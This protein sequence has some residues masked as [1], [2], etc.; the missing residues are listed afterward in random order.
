MTFQRLARIG[1]GLAIALAGF[2]PL[3]KNVA[4]AADLGRYI[5]PDFCAAL[6]VHPA[7]ITK[8]KLWEAIKSGLPPAMA[9]TDP[10]KAAIESIAHDKNA[11]PGIDP[12]KI[13][14]LLEGKN[15]TRVVIFIDPMPKPNIPASFGMIVQFDADIDS[16]ALFAA[17]STGWEPAESNGVKYKKI[18]TGPGEPDAAALMPDAR[19]LIFGIEVSVAK[20]LGDNSSKDQPLLSQLQHSRFDNDVLVEFLADP[21]QAKLANGMLE[22]LAGPNGAEVAKHKN[23]VKALSLKLN[24][25][26]KSLLHLEIVADK[27]ET[28]KTYAAMGTVVINTVAKPQWEEFKKKPNPM[29]PAEAVPV[30]SKLGDEILDGL[31]V[32]ND[33][34]RFV[35]DLAM[36]ASLPDA[37]K[38]AARLG[39]QMAPKP[40]ATPTK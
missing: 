7:R 30:L 25:S 17:F 34:S 10:R 40:A 23:D 14:G 27:E 35:V 15:I 24:F 18:R 33:G 16:D 3:A 13:M 6:V 2:V 21:L 22:K 29:V 36:P 4:S 19:T 31:N 28:A 12:A 9:T 8:S 5:S 1:L 37:A 39:P 20:M 26:G 38:L 32:S 11:P